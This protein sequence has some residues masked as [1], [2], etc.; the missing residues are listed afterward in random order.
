MINIYGQQMSS[1]CQM[2]RVGSKVVLM[3][4]KTANNLFTLE[5]G[6]SMILGGNLKGACESFRSI[7]FSTNLPDSVRVVGFLAASYTRFVM[8]QS[9][10]AFAEQLT[11]FLILLGTR[12]NLGGA[13]QELKFFLEDFSPFEKDLLRTVTNYIKGGETNYAGKITHTSRYDEIFV[14]GMSNSHSCIADLHFESSISSKELEEIKYFGL[15]RILQNGGKVPVKRELKSKY[16]QMFNEGLLLFYKEKFSDAERVFKDILRNNKVPLALRMRSIMKIKTCLERQ[17][18]YRTSVPHI[19]EFQQ[20]LILIRTLK[21]DQTKDETCLEFKK[22][23]NNFPKYGK[24][25][26][27]RFLRKSCWSL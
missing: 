19:W 21:D 23:V 3:T 13:I 15:R 2:Q 16:Y 24:G 18:H 20:L 4:N 25:L 10:R 1:Q 11:D 22:V 6:R 7:A 5:D 27:H 26:P 8:K 14:A 12:S 17:H 9:F